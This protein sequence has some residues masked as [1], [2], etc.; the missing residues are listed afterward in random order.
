MSPP[1]N[2]GLAPRRGLSHCLHHSSR[3]QQ[4]LLA[5]AHLLPTTPSPSQQPC[6]VGTIISTTSNLQMGKLR[7]QDSTSFTQ[8]FTAR[9]RTVLDWN[10]VPSSHALALHQLLPLSQEG[11]LFSEGREPGYSRQEETTPPK[12]TPDSSSLYRDGGEGEREE[13]QS[14]SHSQVPLTITVITA[15]SCWTVIT[16]AWSRE[17]LTAMPLS[18]LARRHCGVES[19][20][21]GHCVTKPYLLGPHHLPLSK[22]KG[23]GKDEGR[24]GT[25]GAHCAAQTVPGMQ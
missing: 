6:E 13:S 1:S 22:E 2:P 14:P 23:L 5:P 20:V 18:P 19:S 21:P 7:H 24:E 17:D 15:W 9:E 3:R 8:G 16:A 4:P 11:C 25:C 12:A 10:P